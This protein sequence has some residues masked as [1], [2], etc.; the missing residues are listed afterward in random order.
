MYFYVNNHK[1][2]LRLVS[3]HNG[4]LRRSDGIYTLGVTDNQIK[5]VFVARGV[6]D[7]M[8]DKVI[9]HELCHV[10]A[11]E[12]DLNMD[13]ETE[14]IVADFLASYGRSVIY[15]ADSIMDNFMKRIS[16]RKAIE[17]TGIYA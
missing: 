2:E 15:T 14:E 4:I 16:T 6:S 11:F 3:A 5:A 13:I 9:C 8:L 1:W 12:Y 17:K 10:Y 7:A